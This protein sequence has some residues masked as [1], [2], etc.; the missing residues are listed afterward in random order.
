MNTPQ[1]NQ[2]GQTGIGAR[3]RMPAV[4]VR[5]AAAGSQPVVAKSARV[6]EAPPKERRQNMAGAPYY[7]GLRWDF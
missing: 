1:A 4:K 5:T 7:R 6:R 3:T 2:S